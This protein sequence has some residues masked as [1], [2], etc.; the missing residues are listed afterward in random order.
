MEVDDK[1][2]GYKNGRKMISVNAKMCSR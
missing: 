1:R 2:K